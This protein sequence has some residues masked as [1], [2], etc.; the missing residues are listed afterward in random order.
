MEFLATEISPDTYVNV[1]PQ[2]HPAGAATRH[3]SIA[4][5]TTL[6]EYHEALLLAREAG[7]HRFD[8][9]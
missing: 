2:Y 4:R 9:R 1:M 3:P 7:I 8:V 5:S 6:N